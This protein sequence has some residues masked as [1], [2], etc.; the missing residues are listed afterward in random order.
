MNRF[1][2]IFKGDKVIWML[3]FFLCIIS[4]VEVY[5]ASSELTYNSDSYTAPILKHVGMLIAGFVIMIVTLNVHCKYFKVLTPIL[6]LFS[7]IALLW[8]FFVGHATNGAS[9]WIEI[10]GI[11]FQ[12]SEI[13]KGSVILAVAQILSAM[14]T[15]IG[16]DRRAFKYILIVALPI[17][18]LIIPENFSTAA[19]LL[20]VVI[21]MM[22]IGRIPTRL[23]L[24][25]VG[26]LAAIGASAIGCIFL[27]GNVDATKIDEQNVLTEQ[28]TIAKDKPEKKGGIEKIFHRFDTW[29]GRI[30]S[31][32]D[33]EEIDIANYDWDKDGQKGHANIAIAS[34]NIIG[35]G[36]GN[37]VA[38]DWLPQAF[39]DFIYAII[40]EEMGIIGGVIVVF[41]FIVLL[42]RA[43]HIASDCARNIPAFLVLGL[44]LLL[45]TQA[46][47]NMCVAV[48]MAPITGQPLPLI[49]K[50]GTSTLINCAYIGMI[51][52]VSRSAKKKGNEVTAID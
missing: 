8:V 11:Q 49:S 42:F 10:F 46:V 37:S 18:L 19:L 38:R 16:A 47:F 22:I 4:I 34:S 9:R 15:E 31:F 40:L 51:L 2:S 27:L 14:Q 13:A 5:S 39:S 30:L 43:Q 50:G 45:V 3:F 32:C 52:S 7:V 23:I 33:N 36:P 41:L 44:A 17:T 24:Y 20:L 28:T 12:P 1:Y 25:F 29:K 6:I 21:M 35:R 48:G 26:V